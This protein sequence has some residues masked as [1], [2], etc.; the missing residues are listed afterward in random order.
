VDVTHGPDTELPAS[1]AGDAGPGTDPD[2]EAEVEPGWSW[3]LVRV[4]GL[5]L[6]VLL[7][8]HFAVVIVRDDV[9][10]TT[11]GTVANRFADGRWQAIEL[12][13]L[14]LA[15]LHGFLALRRVTLGSVRLSPTGRDRVVVAIGAVAVL[16]AFAATWAMLSLS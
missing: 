11:L 2:I 6:A 15:L 16:L 4:T 7:P 1:A 8:L 10:R 14:M 12:V 5:F 9:G 13:T 3:Y